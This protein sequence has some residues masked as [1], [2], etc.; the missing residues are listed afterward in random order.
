M[1]LIILLTLISPIVIG[2]LIIHLLFSR[3][4]KGNRWLWHLWMLFLAPAVGFALVSLLYY[5]WSVIFSPAHAIGVLV[6]IE[7][8]LILILFAVYLVNTR[9]HTPQEIVSL[10]RPAHNKVLVAAA[11]MLLILL[12]ANYF[13][14]WL[15]ESLA[16]PYGDWDAWAIWNLRASFISS[17]DK[18]LT[19]FSEVITWSHPDYPLLLPLNIARIWVLIAQRSVLVP[20]LVSLI[21]QISLLGLLITSIQ[22]QRGYLQGILAGLIGVLVLSTSLAFKLYADIP[23]AYYFLGVNTLLFLDESNPKASYSLAVVTGLLVGAAVWTKNEGWVFLGATVITKII[24]DLASRK[25]SRSRNWWGYFL[26]GLAPLLLATIHFKLVY[27][28]PSD[29]VKNLSFGSMTGAFLSADRYL[30][31]FRFVKDQILE[32]GNLIFPLIPLLL[33]YGIIMGISIPRN[34]KTA[35]MS[36]AL[37][38]TLLTGI[39]FLVYLFTP[40]DLVWHLSTSMERLVTQIFPS[41]IL[42]IFLVVSPPNREQGVQI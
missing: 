27:A 18:W 29:L 35:V 37:R 39:Y 20:I 40:K 28:P 5:M 25:F 13:D 7:V 31:I 30:M 21:F 9:S 38:I 1:N 6:S 22:L 10:P 32:Y 17:G 15:R 3:D 4:G 8:L 11:T 16:A 14:D 12:L 33:I 34:Q 36:L 19:G 41:F 23:I 42:L 2:Y 24:I 26:I